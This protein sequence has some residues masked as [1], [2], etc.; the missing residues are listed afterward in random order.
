MTNLSLSD[1]RAIAPA[2]FS[3]VAHPRTSNRYSLFRTADVVS[4]LAED[5]WEITR[6]GQARV[7]NKANKE[8]CR[9][10]VALSKPELVYQDERVEALITNSN[11]GRNAFRLEL[12]V[13]RF[14]CANGLVDATH[15][16]G[17]IELK[18]FGYIPEQVSAAAHKVVER[19]PQVLE[20]ID[21]WKSKTLST[22]EQVALARFALASRFP[23]KAPIEFE[24]LLRVRRN[25]D[26]GSDLWHVFNRVQE[27][28]IRGGQSYQ[29]PYHGPAEN[30]FRYGGR[31]L[32]V[33]PIR[34][35]GTNLK[36]NKCLWNAAQALYDGQD[37]V[38]PA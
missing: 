18:H 28:S 7:V 34:S 29:R 25:E 14:V 36:L 5:G 1:V 24:E 17:D 20:V 2:A 33:R 30:P 12:G 19:A 32:K 23:E 35:I 37:L 31:N 9:H 38:L 26:V 4:S 15:Q 13:F 21:A 27:N 11:D 6:A 10:I 22:D 16:L 8:F 3:A